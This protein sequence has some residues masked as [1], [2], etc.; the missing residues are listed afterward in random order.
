[1]IMTVDIDKQKWIDIIDS[2]LKSKKKKLNKE[3][4][5]ALIS[6]REQIRVCKTKKNWIDVLKD[7]A[8]IAG[9]AVSI[10]KDD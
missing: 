4:R 5:E 6:L 10:F 9:A 2:V 7:W 8:K 1:M 3:K